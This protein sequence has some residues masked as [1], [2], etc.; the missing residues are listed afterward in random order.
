M[1]QSFVIFF[2]K[3]KRRF[4]PG[5]SNIVLRTLLDM[6]GKF[7]TTFLVMQSLITWP[8]CSDTHVYSLH[9]R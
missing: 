5:I 6:V 7:L 8:A 3:V 1:I 4:F 2:K 9:C